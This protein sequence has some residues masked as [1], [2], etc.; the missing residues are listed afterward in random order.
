MSNIVDNKL[1][2]EEYFKK[3]NNIVINKSC[4]ES[5]VEEILD[6]IEADDKINV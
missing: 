4:G 2:N 5:I 3:L 1:R 6:E